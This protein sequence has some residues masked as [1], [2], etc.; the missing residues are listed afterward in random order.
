MKFAHPA[1][2]SSDQI[3]AWARRLTDDL[4]RFVQLPEAYPTFAD[5][6]AAAAGNLKVGQPYRSPDGLLRW[7]AS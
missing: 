4:N 5:D 7:R 1:G 3:A 6:A 2:N